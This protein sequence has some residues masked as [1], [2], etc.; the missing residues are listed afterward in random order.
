MIFPRIDD[1]FVDGC[2]LDIC[3][4]LLL[5]SLQ[6]LDRLHEPDANRQPTLLSFCHPCSAAGYRDTSKLGFHSRGAYWHRGN[7]GMGDSG[8]KVFFCLQS[9]LW[10][11][12]S[13]TCS[14]FSIACVPIGTSPEKIALR[15]GRLVGWSVSEPAERTQLIICALWVLDESA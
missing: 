7:D 2:V 13:F 4:M 5:I 6:E 8:W 10:V 15:I 3:L 9:I 12:S 14:L 11:A 1:V